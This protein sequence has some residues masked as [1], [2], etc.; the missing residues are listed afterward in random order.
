[1]ANTIVGKS[2]VSVAIKIFECNFTGMGVGVYQ[3]LTFS[4]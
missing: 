4:V 2:T 3:M 1:M